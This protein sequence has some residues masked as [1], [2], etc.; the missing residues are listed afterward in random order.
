MTHYHVYLRKSGPGTVDYTAWCVPTYD[1]AAVA[2]R[3]AGCRTPVPP[4]PVKDEWISIGT[5]VVIHAEDS[6]FE[7]CTAGD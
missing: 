6:D 1:G 2:L 4:T 3:R 5:R 7:T